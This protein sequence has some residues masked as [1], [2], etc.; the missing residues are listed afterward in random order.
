MGKSS[1]LK[2]MVEHFRDNWLEK[3]LKLA[4]A[5]SRCRVTLQQLE[6]EASADENIIE[7]G[8]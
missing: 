8:M 4:S 7:S 5:K 2:G 3:I 1:S 6:E